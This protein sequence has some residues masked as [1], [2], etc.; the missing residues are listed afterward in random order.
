MDNV[1]IK[2]VTKSSNVA[3]PEYE[4]EGAAAFDLQCQEDFTIWPGQT[5][6]IGTG[7]FCEIPPGYELSV[8]SRSGLAAKKNIVVLNAPGTI[9]SDYR[10]ELRVILHYAGAHGESHSFKKGARIAQAA[11]AR[12]I[13][14]FFE[15]TQEL[16][17]T[18]RGS[19]GFGSTGL[20]KV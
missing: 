2:I 3:L 12:V 9:D 5:L 15:H 13:R 18:G 1:I 8:R 7:L 11:P 10:G 17:E 19:D 6:V 4:T 20:Y 16:S 14:A